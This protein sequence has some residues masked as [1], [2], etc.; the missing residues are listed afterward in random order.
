MKL[1]I[2]DL[3]IKCLSVSWYSSLIFFSCFKLHARKSPDYSLL[4]VYALLARILA[5]VS[6]K[7]TLG[8]EVTAF[9]G[10][11]EEHDKWKTTEESQNARENRFVQ[12]Q[13]MSSLS[14]KREITIEV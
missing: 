5:C 11:R 3:I 8:E 13:E 2:H 10:R 4:N 1:S 6:A 9:A 14:T 12:A 7:I